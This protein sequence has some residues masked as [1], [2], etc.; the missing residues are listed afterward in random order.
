MQT[1]HKNR[2]KRAGLGMI[3]TL[4]LALTAV[5]AAGPAQ[6]TAPSGDSAVEQS[7][8]APSASAEARSLTKDTLT[9]SPT[10]T[11]SAP[12]IHVAETTSLPCETGSFCAAVWDPTVD[13]YEVF[14]FDTC[15]RYELSNWRNVG[16]FGNKTG[17][18]GYFYDENGNTLRSVISGA[19]NL[20]NWNSVAS[21][22]SC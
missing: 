4:G 13:Q 19:A 14:S 1:T 3:G 18:T 12:S 5:F 9:V 21:I 2:A 16:V 10:T 15:Q 11:P 20:Y 7:V 22:R 8:T 17:A 6:A